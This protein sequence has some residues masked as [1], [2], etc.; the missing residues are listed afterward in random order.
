MTEPFSLQ[1]RPPEFS[2]KQLLIQDRG[3]YHP[4]YLRPYGLHVEAQNALAVATR[5]KAVGI[6]KVAGQL[7]AGISPRLVEPA[8]VPE[9]KAEIPGGWGMSRHSFLIELEVT[10][11]TTAHI[12]YIQGYTG[13]RGITY[14]GDKVLIDPDMTWA[15]N[16]IL[17]LAKVTVQTSDQGIIQDIVLGNDHFLARSPVNSLQESQ[18]RL[19]RPQ[20]VFT[21]FEM[22]RLSSINPHHDVVDTRSLLSYQTVRSARAHGL[23]LTYLG[24]ILDGYL[25]SEAQLQY[26]QD[27]HEILSFG[28]QAILQAP[29]LESPFISA[30]SNLQNQGTVR[31]FTYGVLQKIDASVDQKLVYR[32]SLKGSFKEPQGSL[33]QNQDHET[34]WATV[35]GHAVLALM[36]GV[37]IS[38]LHLRST[39]QTVTGQPETTV[40]QAT[41]LISEPTDSEIQA[42]VWRLEAEVLKDLISEHQTSYQLEIQSDWVGDTRITLALDSRPAVTY[43]VPT[44]C[45]NLF[46]PVLTQTEGY[47]EQ[48]ADDFDQLLRYIVE[49]R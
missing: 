5:L 48:L 30:I 39:N 36:T 15:V 2:I 47:L 12:F 22:E 1:L 41:G 28:K 34:F 6:R 13:H 46:L 45:D 43:V 25:A 11:G 27:G 8:V 49:H 14:Q 37:K 32:P 16:S 21:A 20:D 4:L 3:P 18:Q 23:P 9:V 19:L 35:L 31:E 7:L 26:T 40:V 38:A 44:F 17:H 24:Q 29:A 10:L 42:M 33:W